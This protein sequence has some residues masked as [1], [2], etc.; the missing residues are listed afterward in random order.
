MA[1]KALFIVVAFFATLV[2][3]SMAKVHYVGGARGWTLNFDYQTWA[4]GQEF[5]V[6]DD[7]VFR[8]PVGVHNVAK[9]NGTGFQTCTAPTDAAPLTSGY[10]VIR[11]AASGKK[12]YI[13]SVGVHCAVG[14][15]KLVIDVLPEG[16]AESPAS[17]PAPSPVQ[18]IPTRNAGRG[19]FGTFGKFVPRLGH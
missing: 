1:S 11:L 19:L 3:P 16:S 2:A 18:W 15:M 4:S 17:A 13:C 6:G 10:D 8:Y 9:V 14:G 7:L 5:H 12:W